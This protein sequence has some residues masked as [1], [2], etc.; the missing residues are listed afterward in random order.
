MPLKFTQI[1]IC[2]Q[3]FPETVSPCYFFFFPVGTGR[4]WFWEVVTVSQVPC[5]VFLLQV[6]LPVACNRHDAILVFW[7][8]FHEQTVA[9]SKEAVIAQTYS[10][11]FKPSWRLNQDCLPLHVLLWISSL[12]LWVPF[13]IPSGTLNVPSVFFQCFHVVTLFFFSCQYLIF[14]LSYSRASIYF[15]PSPYPY[16]FFPLGHQTLSSILF[17]I[18]KL[19]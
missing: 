8:P 17:H 18:N 14:L 12:F 16:F 3:L 9:S 13:L 4:Y 10:C 7:S 11:G 1:S 6:H 15:L 5:D 19:L 2:L